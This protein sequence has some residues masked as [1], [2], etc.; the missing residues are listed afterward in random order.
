[1]KLGDS[2]I[3]N[4]KPDR[5]E[6]KI[7]DGE[8]LQLVVKPNGS[9]LWQ[10]RYR[11][12]EK[13]RTLSLGKYP[14]VTLKN[15]RKQRSAAQELLSQRID[16]VTRRR[17]EKI[18]GVYRDRNSFR[19]VAEGWRERNRSKWTERHDKKTWGRLEKHVFPYIG[20]RPISGLALMDVLSVLQRIESKGTA[21]KPMIEMAHRV[22]G[23]CSA[24]F[25][26]GIIV[27]ACE[28]DP[29]E[30]LG[31]ALKPYR[32]KHFASL[33]ERELPAFLRSLENLNTAEQNKLAM[34]MLIHT[35]VR[36]GELRHARWEDIGVEGW[37]I[38][39]EFTKMRREHIVP[40]SRQVRRMLEELHE[41]TGHGKWLFPNQQGRRHPIMS[42]NTINSL[43]VRMGFQGK[44]VGH[45][46]RSTFSTVLNERGFNR[47]AIERQLAHVEQNEVRAAYN[48]A[49]YL[50]ERRMMMQWWSDRIEGLQAGRHT[51]VEQHSVRPSERW[52]S[53]DSSEWV[54]VPKAVLVE[55]I[56]SGSVDLP[57]LTECHS[58]SI[59]QHVW[60]V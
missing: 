14:K 21:E 49:E 7:S 31:G 59:P 40:L 15:A 35:A 4:A 13:E 12:A 48:R 17:E 50:E 16:P 22:R 56:S 3:R 23:L 20:S 18:Q 19:A 2:K 34:R 5:K 60:K 47:D 29:A 24:I 41:L 6:Y 57:S 27:G 33:P 36:T 54:M 44:A 45:G 55:L 25:R 38:P 37:K 10:F 58:P 9:K 51:L 28:S 53:G 32:P 46:F 52:V 30:R 11:F 1:M 42:E 43:I 39:A 8:G 26:F